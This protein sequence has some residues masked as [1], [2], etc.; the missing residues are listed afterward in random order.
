MDN[1]VVN[2]VEADKEDHPKMVLSFAVDEAGQMV[3]IRDA[4]NGLGCKCMCPVCHG[5]LIARQGSIREWHFAHDSGVECDNAVETAL[6]LAAKQLLVNAGGMMVPG[7]DVTKSITIPGLDEIQ[8]EASQAA[9]HVEFLSV[10][11]EKDIGH[12]RPDL[13]A[14][15]GSSMLIIEVAVTHFV[16]E[17]KIAALKAGGIPTVEINL[18]SYHRTEWTWD[19]LH[20]AVVNS[21]EC[22][23][24]VVNMN[25]AVLQRIAFDDAIQKIGDQPAIKS[26][27]G[28][29][30][31]LG[32]Y[33]LYG[34]PVELDMRFDGQ[35]GNHLV[36]TIRRHSRLA[37][38][39][40]W[41]L[42]QRNGGYYEDNVFIFPA[43]AKDFLIEYLSGN[44]KRRAHA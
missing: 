34:A 10:E 1:N 22:K 15:T 19:S 8:G 11:M 27:V 44:Y 13:L 43:R 31:P 16:G 33:T 30:E 17:E 21:V 29:S 6:H 7:V 36:A 42:M 32:S 5:P 12:L 23:H 35:K 41:F 18:A 3:S 40:L 37:F 4:E 2:I 20:E 38:D 28:Q 14:F 39:K 9:G 26:I 24:W 25:E